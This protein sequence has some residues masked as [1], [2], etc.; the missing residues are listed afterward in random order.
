MI[1]STRE[2]RRAGNHEASVTPADKTMMAP[3]QIHGSLAG[4]S[5]H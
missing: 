3:S 2:A 5:G 4:I 1:G